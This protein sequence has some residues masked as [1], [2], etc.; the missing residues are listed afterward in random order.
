MRF[1]LAGG[2]AHTSDFQRDAQSQARK[3]M[4]AIQHHMLRVQI[5]DGVN[6]LFGHLA[7]A[8]SGQGV[9]FDGHAFFQAF[10]K[11]TARL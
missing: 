10:W 11:K 2:M 9:A 3:R 4:V 5:G 1:L 8:C 7:A 6:H